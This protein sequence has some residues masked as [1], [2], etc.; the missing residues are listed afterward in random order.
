MPT[1]R[2]LVAGRMAQHVPTGRRRYCEAELCVP[3]ALSRHAIRFSSLNG[4]LR[5]PN[6]PAARARSRSLSSGSAVTKITGVRLPFA[7]SRLCRSTPFMPGIRTSVIRHSVSRKRPDP[8]NSSPD[9][10]V[11]VA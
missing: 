2:E 8:R 5:K 11:A 9:A 1:I 10:K 6:A 4:L 7:I 3:V